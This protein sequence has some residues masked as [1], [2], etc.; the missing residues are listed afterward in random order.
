[1]GSTMRLWSFDIVRSEDGSLRLGL[2]FHVE[3]NLSW[4]P[5]FVISRFLA[6]QPAMTIG[7]IWKMARTG[8]LP[9]SVVTLTEDEPQGQMEVRIICG[10]RVFVSSVCCEALTA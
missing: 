2:I 7:M 9:R 5:A 8:L 3:K 4:L 1:M 6:K 10:E